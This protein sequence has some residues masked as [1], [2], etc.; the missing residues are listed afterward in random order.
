[1]H[2]AITSDVPEKMYEGMLISYRI[3]LIPG[4]PLN[5]VTEITR[6]NEGIYFVDEQRTGPYKMWHHEHHFEP[7]QGGVL[8]TDLLYYD[9]GKSVFGW[10]AGQL[11]VH[12][13]VQQI[14]NYRRKR[15]EELFPKA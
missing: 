8:M 12:R 1:M 6:I 4:I 2:F 5:W 10:L 13:K 14:F 11:F 9:I 3:G 15:L 7:A